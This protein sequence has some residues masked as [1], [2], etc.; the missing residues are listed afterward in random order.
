MARKKKLQILGLFTYVVF[1]IIIV[2]IFRPTYLVNL[3]IVYLPPSLINYFW[4]KKS[5]HKI[6]LFSIITVLLFAPPIELVA[7]LA[8]AWD[9]QSTLPRLFGTAP[10]EN[11]IYAFFNFFWPLCF[12]EY[13]IDKDKSYKTSKKLKYLVGLYLALSLAVYVSFAIYGELIAINYWLVGVGVLLPSILILGK[14]PKLINKIILPTI[15]FGLVFFVHEVMSLELGHWWWP[16]EYLL[17]IKLFGNQFP[18]DDALIW[19]VF[20]TPALIGGYEFFV[21]DNK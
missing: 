2:Y 6:L 8:D 15:F 4:L 17:P 5:G 12:Y 1:A 3:F 9:V 20:S 10:I 13:F 7:R 16:G 19:Y 21:D 11:L 18:L 14:N